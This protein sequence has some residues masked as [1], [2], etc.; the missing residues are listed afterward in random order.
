MQLRERRIYRSSGNDFESQLTLWLGRCVMWQ[1]YKSNR[2]STLLE[3]RGMFSSGGSHLTREAIIKIYENLKPQIR[4]ETNEKL[5][6]HL[7]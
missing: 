2:A 5:K 1:R 4:S 3:D 6:A 7:S